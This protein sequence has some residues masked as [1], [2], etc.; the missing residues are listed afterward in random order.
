MPPGEK[1]MQKNG[2]A[3]IP[4]QKHLFILKELIDHH[5]RPGSTLIDVFG[6]RTLK[7]LDVY[8]NLL[9]DILLDAS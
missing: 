1:V 3:L 7:E 6:A 9:P 4:E 8:R 5:S 2:I